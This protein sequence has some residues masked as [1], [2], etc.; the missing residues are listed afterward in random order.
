MRIRIKKSK[1]TNAWYMRDYLAGR[2]CEVLAIGPDDDYFVLHPIT[3]KTGYWI[4]KENCEVVE[5]SKVP[6]WKHFLKNNSYG[7]SGCRSPNSIVRN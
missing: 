1:H 6:T 2:T 4:T 7:Y 3:K 5:K